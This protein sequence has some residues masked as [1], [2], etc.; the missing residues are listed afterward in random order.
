[1]SPTTIVGSCHE[2]QVMSSK[3]VPPREPGMSLSILACVSLPCRGQDG[4]VQSYFS[5]LLEM[6]TVARDRRKSFNCPEKIHLPL[7]ERGNWAML[8]WE[9]RVSPSCHLLL[10]GHKMK[11]GGPVLD[12]NGSPLSLFPRPV[13]RC[14]RHPHPPP[15]S[16]PP[17]L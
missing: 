8:V 15:K 11:P 2:V 5:F 3:N 12:E 1:M 17:W 16:L 14:S 9:A 13:L 6:T 7:E 4:G 10:V